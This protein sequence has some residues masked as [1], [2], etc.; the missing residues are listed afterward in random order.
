[1]VVAAI[2]D[3]PAASIHPSNAATIAGATSGSET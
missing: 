2:D 1:M 3:A